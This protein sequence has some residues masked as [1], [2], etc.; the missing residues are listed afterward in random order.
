MELPPLGS[1]GLAVVCCYCLTVDNN[2]KSIKYISNL[3]L[4][5]VPY[6]SFVKRE[7][8]MFQIILDIARI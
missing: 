4:T 5:F 8:N 6:K 2:C 3:Y 7:G 1:E